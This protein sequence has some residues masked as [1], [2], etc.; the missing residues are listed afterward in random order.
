MI[1]DLHASCQ[2][3]KCHL[4]KNATTGTPEWQTKNVIFFPKDTKAQSEPGLRMQ[5]VILSMN[6]LNSS[7]RIIRNSVRETPKF[8]QIRAQTGRGDPKRNLQKARGLRGRSI[9]S[10]F[11]SLD[12]GLNTFLT[13]PNHLPFFPMVPHLAPRNN[14]SEEEQA[15]S[16][17]LY[18]SD[19]T[20][21][22]DTETTAAQITHRERRKTLVEEEIAK[23]FRGSKETKALSVERS[24]E[25]ETRRRQRGGGT[26]E[27]RRGLQRNHVAWKVVGG[28]RRRSRRQTPTNFG[29]S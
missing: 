15:K 25:E 17:N 24:S 26:A 8:A 28:A 21:D 29:W 20:L 22:D 2:G 19:P 1:T 18:L 10:S 3:G 9:T 13:A 23:P 7:Y 12:S 6:T 14:H 27:L 4:D 16:P 5:D 11:F